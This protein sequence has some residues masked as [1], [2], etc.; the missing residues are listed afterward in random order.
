MAF[1]IWSLFLLAF[2][3]RVCDPPVSLCGPDAPQLFSLSSG[4]LRSFSGPSPTLL[5]PPHNYRYCRRRH[6]SRCI[7]T[8]R[9]STVFL[10]LLL[11]C[12]DVE[13]NPGPPPSAAT[14][15]CVCPSSREE[16]DMLQCELC[17][18]WSHCECVNIPL[19][20][21][22]THPFVCAHCIKSSVVSLSSLH[23]KLSALEH[24][25]SCLSS[26]LDSLIA[27]SMPLPLSPS[28]HSKSASNVTPESISPSASPVYSSVPFS[29]HFLFLHFLLPLPLL[30]FV[31]FGYITQLISLSLTNFFLPFPGVLSFLLLML[32][33]L[34]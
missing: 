6:R 13:P 16:G 31:V 15:K 30:P 23:C 18:S 12:G 20:L 7:S 5:L 21:A 11:L 3:V 19:A 2:L 32:T 17:F 9:H 28:I 26:R 8:F 25:L 27:R 34:G 1:V 10:L 4:G 14:I 29:S 24:S 22:S 33:P